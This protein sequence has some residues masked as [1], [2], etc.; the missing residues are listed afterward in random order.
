MLHDKGYIVLRNAV[1]PEIYKV[2]QDNIRQNDVNYDIIGN[3]V[4]RYISIINAKTGMDLKCSKYRA[5]NNNNSVDAG[6]LHVDVKK[7]APE[8]MKEKIPVFTC[9]SYLDKTIMELVPFTHLDGDMTLVKSMQHFRNRIQIELNPGDLLVIYSTLLHRGI[10]YKNSKNRRL[11]Q[12][13]GCINRDQYK[14]YNDKIVHVGCDTNCNNTIE[15]A[16][17]FINKYAMGSVV[18]NIASYFNASMGHGFKWGYMDRKFPMAEAEGNNKRL[19]PKFKGFEPINRYIINQPDLNN[20]PSD[21]WIKVGTQ[22]N[23]M[24]GTIV[25]IL[26]LLFL[27][28]V[29]CRQYSFIRV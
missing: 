6:H 13:F 9:L 18:P 25:F 11:I 15:K 4:D 16:S 12:G 29:G 5:S 26:I 2:A 28:T 20:A 1:P 21:N 3:Y 19:K 17:V 10:F 14:M 8:V 22:L 27:L 24:I 7:V 23:G